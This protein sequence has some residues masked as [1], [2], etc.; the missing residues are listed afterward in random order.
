[1]KGLHSAFALAILKPCATRQ[2]WFRLKTPGDGGAT[3]MQN[4]SEMEKEAEKG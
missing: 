2:N 3:E 1:M 4:E